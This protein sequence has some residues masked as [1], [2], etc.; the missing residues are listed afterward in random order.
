MG[1]G[2]VGVDGAGEA[3]WRVPERGDVGRV[4]RRGV[5][6]SCFLGKPAPFPSKKTKSGGEGGEGGTEGGGRGGGGD[7]A[8]GGRGGGRGGGG[9]RAGGAGKGGGGGEIIILKQCKI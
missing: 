6:G 2:R 7:R 1:W 8:G 5:E 3:C 9:G 4:R